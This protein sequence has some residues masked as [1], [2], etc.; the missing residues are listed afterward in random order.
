M[1]SKNQR[2]AV[3]STEKC[4]PRKCRQECKT[5][6]PVVRAGKFCVT[7]ESS[8]SSA[9]INEILCIGCG[10]CV[11]R[12]P[13]EA[14]Q[15]INL[16]KEIKTNPVHRYGNNKFQL[17]NLP[18]PKT[19]QILG[20]IGTN[21]IG[22]STALKILSGNLKPNLGNF[23]DPPEWITIQK[24]FRGGDL[25]TYF[26]LL[27]KKKLKILIK[28][29]YIDVISE[30]TK[31]SV[32]EIF[33]KKDQKG[34]KTQIIK[35]FSM[36]EILDRKINE[37]SGGELQRF[38]IALIL[39]QLGDVLLIDEFSS[40]LD[41]KQKIQVANEI[42]N[43]SQEE[44]TK[45]IIM[46]EHDLSIMDYMSD[47]ICCLY[48]RPG[49]YGIVSI[50]FTVKEGV[51]IFLSGYIP[52]EN[53]R[54][55]ENSIT[56]SSVKE[57]FQDSVSNSKSSFDYPE[58]EKKIGNFFLSIEPGKFHN[59]DII[60]LLGENGMGKTSFVKIM[61]GLLK[62]DKGSITLNRMS[63]SYKPQKISPSYDGTVKSLLLEKIGNF[64]YDPD[65]RENIIKSFDIESLMNKEVKKTIR[66]RTSENC[67]SSMFG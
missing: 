65:F 66:W 6:C 28:P 44:N 55:R 61:G 56:F 9:I 5:N 12:C 40:Y 37:L 38:A 45:F 7:V 17:F 34:K 16:P 21:G 3:V 35:N 8:D 58:M 13:Y 14:I 49:V 50:P 4:K 26:N 24:S 60:I 15:I 30:T 27:L 64:L 52:T 39:I 62:P 29:Q 53:V 36:E 54:F 11:K 20:I 23:I 19:G 57:D 51:N 43:V 22:K 25:Q 41:I 67:N 59:S 32:S 31:G 10:I 47:F 63:F 18:A 33:T 46:T 1:N 48:G 2:I 42:K